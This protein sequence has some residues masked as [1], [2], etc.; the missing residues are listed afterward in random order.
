M[1]D[2]N[3]FRVGRPDGTTVRLETIVCNQ[4][5]AGNDVAEGRIT[6][7]EYWTSVVAMYEAQLRHERHIVQQLHRELSAIRHVQGEVAG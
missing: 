5:Q 7:E 2:S 6:P 3:S 1:D 4:E